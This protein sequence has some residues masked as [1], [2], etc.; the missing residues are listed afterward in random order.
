ML[1]LESIPPYRYEPKREEH[2]C[3]EM[4]E[5]IS[6]GIKVSEIPSGREVRYV[7]D[8]STD[9]GRV[10]ELCRLATEGILDPIHLSYVIEDFVYS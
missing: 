3:E 1:L 7:C 4:G 5:Y 8:V 6:Y 10:E 9:K 2:F